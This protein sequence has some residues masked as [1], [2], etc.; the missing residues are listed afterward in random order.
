MRQQMNRVLFASFFSDEWQNVYN[1]QILSAQKRR[2]KGMREIGWEQKRARWRES[3]GAMGLLSSRHLLMQPPQ[4]KAT[5][6]QTG[7]A[8]WNSFS[9]NGDET[10]RLCTDVTAHR[11][12][13]VAATFTRWMIAN[14]WLPDLQGDLR[15]SLASAFGICQA[16]PTSCGGW[17]NDVLS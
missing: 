6:D 2:R 10:L 17:G 11:Q 12:T 9:C 4:W 8:D 14:T 1:S 5:A 16:R 13:Q 3:D 7:Q 15:L